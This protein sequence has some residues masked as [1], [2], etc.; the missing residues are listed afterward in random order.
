MVKKYFF[1]SNYITTIIVPCDAPFRVR[2]ADHQAS[3]SYPSPII[4]SKAKQEKDGMALQIQ[5]SYL[6]P[7]LHLFTQHFRRTL[8]LSDF[9]KS[10]GCAL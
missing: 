1:V 5:T 8:I 7:Q 2:F 4:A 9:P 10:K 6:P 3:S